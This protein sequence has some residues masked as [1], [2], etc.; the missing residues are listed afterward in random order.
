MLQLFKVEWLKIRT[1][2]TFW[3]LFATF[4]ILFPVALYFTASKYMEPRAGMEEQTIKAFLGSPF[5]FSKIWQTSS[6]FGGMFFVM[7]GMLFILLITNEV[8]YRTHRQNIIDGWSR[9]DFLKAKFSL[10]IFFVLIA[11]VLVFIS[12]LIVGSVFS[13]TNDAMWE[14]LHYI[15]YFALMATIYLMVAFL[16]AI[17]VKRTGLSIIVYFAF[18]CIVDNI[19]WLIMTLYNNQY[20]YFLPLETTDSLIVNPFK[21]AMMEKRTVSDY[22]LIGTAVFYILLF[23][24]IITRY[25]KR[26]DLK[27]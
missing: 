1:Y 5:I 4:C 20:G 3:L 18:V 26:T 16:I 19:L 21:P 6:W 8:Q 12:G 7:M 14:N 9:M 10:L 15:G 22:A 11:T 13:V 23:G 2:K 25:F 17:L 27:T 24:F